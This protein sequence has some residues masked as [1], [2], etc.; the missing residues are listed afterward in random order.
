MKNKRSRQLPFLSIF[1]FC[2]TDLIKTMY[3]TAWK[4]LLSAIYNFFESRAKKKFFV[5]AEAE[6]SEAKSL[7]RQNARLCDDMRKGAA[8]S[9]LHG[10]TGLS[11]LSRGAAQKEELQCSARGPSLLS[12]R[13]SV[14]RRPLMPP[15]PIK[16][17]SAR[18]KAVGRRSRCSLPCQA[19]RI[20]KNFDYYLDERQEK[21]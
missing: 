19:D 1:R 14:R 17:K 7:W 21:S 2:S 9:A 4:S 15:C 6:K 13:I 8:H 11:F 18:S 12:A 10:R 3:K 20:G 5:V 16:E